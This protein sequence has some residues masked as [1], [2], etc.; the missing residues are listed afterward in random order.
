MTRFRN[1]AA[2]SRMMPVDPVWAAMRERESAGCSAIRDG[3]GLSGWL[4]VR[5][6]SPSELRSL[7][8]LTHALALGNPY[9]M[10]QPKIDFITCASSRISEIPAA[11]DE[12]G[13]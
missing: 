9:A 5:D 2:T 11:L 10:F 13:L 6:R 1:S 8:G 3:R 4:P 7:I 12:F